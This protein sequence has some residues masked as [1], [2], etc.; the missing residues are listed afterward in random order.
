M[1][2]ASCTMPLRCLLSRRTEK[3]TRFPVRPLLNNRDCRCRKARLGSGAG[4]QYQKRAPSPP[5]PC[6]TRAE[7]QPENT[8]SKDWSEGSSQLD[9]GQNS[10]CSLLRCLSVVFHLAKQKAPCLGALFFVSSSDFVSGRRPS[11]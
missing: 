6:R 8:P 11:R 2:G 4:H 7:A 1:Y 10:W 9:R 3:K 5:Q